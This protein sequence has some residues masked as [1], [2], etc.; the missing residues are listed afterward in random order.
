MNLGLIFQ[1]AFA[2]GLTGFLIGPES[3]D[4]FIGMFPNNTITINVIV[5]V[6]AG[7][8]VGFVDPIGDTDLC[9]LTFRSL[10]VVQRILQM[11]IRTAPARPV[12]RGTG[13]IRIH[14]EYGLCGQG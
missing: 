1:L 8:A 2:G 12:M 9:D 11:K 7:A 10:S 3:L 14:V 6:L 13:R 5:G 4:Q